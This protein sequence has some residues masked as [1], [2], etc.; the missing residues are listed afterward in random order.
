MK[1]S[2]MKQMLRYA[3]VVYLMFI[4]FQQVRSS[5]KNKM[6]AKKHLFHMLIYDWTDRQT[7]G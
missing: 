4:L 3:F 7:S 1:Q 2:K 5:K 6:N